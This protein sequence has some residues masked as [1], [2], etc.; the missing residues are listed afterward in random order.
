MAELTPSQI[1]F[2]IA[3]LIFTAVAAASDIRT[4]KI[5]NKMTVP[6]CFA[7]LLYQ[8]IFFQWDGLWAALSGFGAG[9]G[10]FFLLWMVGSAGGG[11]VKLMGALG[12]WMGGQLM[13]KVMLVSL[14][15]VA[16]GTF[17]IVVWSVLLKGLSRTKSQYLK[18]G[19]PVET[20]DARQKRRVMAF[21]APVALA[22][23]SV[24]A[25]QLLTGRGI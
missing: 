17:S 4:R 10:L 2:L 18:N 24:V 22:T 5:P 14:I 15:F 9:F 12:P 20:S 11:D 23:W 19:S 7:G 1:I 21:A 25:V 16:I 13:L 3:V 6:M 8:L